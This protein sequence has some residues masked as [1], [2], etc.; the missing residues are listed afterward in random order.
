MRDGKCTAKPQQ[1]LDVD[2]RTNA[3]RSQDQW[4]HRPTI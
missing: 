1:E 3:G 2:F 4:G